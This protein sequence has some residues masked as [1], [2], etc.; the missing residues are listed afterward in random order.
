[1]KRLV[2]VAAALL[3]AAC[4]SSNVEPPAPLVKFTPKIKVERVWSHSV[5][6]SDSILRLG[7]VPASDGTNVYTA[8]HSGTV[9]AYTLK[10]GDQA[11]RVKT[12]L[13]ISAG[14]GVGEGM[15]VVA[16]S[17]GS[18]QALSTT[19]GKQLWKTS[20]NGYVLASPAVSQTAVVVCTTDGHEIALSPLTG[21]VLWSV[22]HDV[23]NLS[24]RGASPP[25][26]SGN[27]VYQGLDSGN[28]LALNLSDGSQRWSTPVSTPSGSNELARL[29]DVDGI[30]AVDGDVIYAVNYQ[31]RLV[32][33]VR[34]S[35][36]VLWSR[37]MSSYTGVGE[38][39]TNIYV[40]DVH[41]AVWALEKATGVPVWTQPAMRA[42]DL[43]VPVPY[44]NTVVAG[45]LEGYLH[46]LSKKDGSIVARVRLGSSPILAPPIVVNGYLVVLT[47]GANLAAYQIKPLTD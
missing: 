1:M 47:T 39:D 29:V 25:V 10:D 27:T 2:S 33:L 4:A 13:P 37:E 38:D 16:A 3:V 14:P 45:D 20:V 36:Q 34:Y 26:I 7:I 23:P 18:V 44:M 42:R 30:L 22:S 40:T 21:Q 9:Y 6:S 19:N 41:S 35:G 31:G 28:V 24:L 32:E 8:S 15:V 11:W 43:T 5:G 12:K 46:F 17:D